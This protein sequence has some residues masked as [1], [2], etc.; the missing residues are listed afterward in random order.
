M[1]IRQKKN[2]SNV[3]GEGDILPNCSTTCGKIKQNVLILSGQ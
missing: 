2:K 3:K 1:K